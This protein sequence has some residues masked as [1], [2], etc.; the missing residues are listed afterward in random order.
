MIDIPAGVEDGQTVRIKVDGK[1]EAIVQVKIDDDSGIRREGF[2]VYSDLWLN[3]WEVALGLTVTVKGLNGPLKVKIPKNLSSHSVLVLHK[4]G[5][6]KFNAPGQFGNHYVTVKIRSLDIEKH[7]KV[8]Q[9]AGKS[10][11]VQ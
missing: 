9:D 1:H 2:H 4:K 3:I 7:L 5:F 6:P 11:S 8:I 10:A